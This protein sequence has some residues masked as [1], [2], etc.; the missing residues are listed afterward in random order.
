[1]KWLLTLV[2][3]CFAS[4]VQAQ[5]YRPYVKQTYYQ[6]P[7]Y[8]SYYPTYYPYAYPVIV[9]VE[10][11]RDRYYSLSD[12]YRDRMLLEMFDQWKNRATQEP[13]QAPATHSE[14]LPGPKGEAQA[15]KPQG[16]AYTKA[17]E[18]AASLLKANCIT[19]HGQGNQYIDLSNIDA[20]PPTQRRAAF[21]MLAAGDMPPPP[22]ELLVAGKEKELADWKQKNAIPEKDLQEIYEGWVRVAQLAK[23]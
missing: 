4:T 22:K 19:C 5:C 10:V 11:Q 16:K 17:S 8:Q 3:L 7:H 20:V 18:K 13:Q 15:P 21:G 14:V 9:A 1:M 2:T 12:I 6:Q 23:K